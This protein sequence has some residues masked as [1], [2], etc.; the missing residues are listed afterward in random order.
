MYA[1]NFYLAVSIDV[2]KMGRKMKADENG[3]RG[4]IYTTE[5]G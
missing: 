2:E 5:K 1:I 3:N 4:H